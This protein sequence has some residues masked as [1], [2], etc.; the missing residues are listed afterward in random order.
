MD[1][2]QKMFDFSSNM[3]LIANFHNTILN[4]TFWFLQDIFARP[5]L[6]FIYK[7]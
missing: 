5:C 4:D 3:A 6:C 2:R 1:Y 7:K